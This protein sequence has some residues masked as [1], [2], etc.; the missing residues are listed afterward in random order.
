MAQDSISKYRVVAIGGSA[1]SLEV[2]LQIFGSLPHD[3]GITYILI[4]HRKN[5]ADSILDKLIA[6]RTAMP[7]YEVDDKDAININSVYIAPPDYHLL[8]EDQHTFSL[9]SS[10][11]ISFSRPSID[12][13]FESAAEI[14][15]AAAIGVILS[16]ANADGAEGL[17]K[18]KEAGGF[19]VVQSPESAEVDYMPKQVIGLCPDHLV[20]TASEIGKVIAALVGQLQAGE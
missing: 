10:E 18:I 20:V 9:D 3:A 5:D 13:T 11:K 15:G 14:F 1:G 2:I 6:A 7:V 19:T 8:L 4:L 12:V 17:K 16:G